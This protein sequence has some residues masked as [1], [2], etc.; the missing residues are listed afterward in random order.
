M[1][2]KSEV[3]QLSK[4]AAKRELARLSEEIARANIAYHQED[5]PE[6][7][8]ADFDALVLRARAIEERFP[9]LKPSG[10]ALDKVGA[11]PSGRFAKVA[12]AQPMLSLDNAF[13]SEEVRDFVDR[14]R[15]FLSLGEEEP[16]TLL[17]EPKI[18]GLA[19]SLRYE[20]GMLVHG[21]TRGDGDVGED[22][23]ANLRTLDSIPDR[24][25]NVPPVIE[26]R[27][28]VYM[29]KADFVALNER[30]AAA[31][32]KLFANP[33]NGAAGSLRQL[34]VSVT[35][36]RPLRFYA[37]GWG[38]VSSLTCE[39]QSE[40]MDWLAGLGFET[41]ERA[42]GDTDAAL[43]FYR[44]LEEQ[45]GDLAFDIDG[46][47][48][49]I[50]RLDWQARLGKVGRAPRWAVAHKFPAEKAITRLADIDHQVGRTGKL[51]PVARLDP[52]TVGGVVVTNATLHN[53]DEIARLD[54]RVGDRV[55]LQ[56]AGDVIPQ[57]LRHVPEKGHDK[58]PVYEPPSQCPVCTSAAVR[59]AGEVARRCTGGLVCE[60]QSVE[61]LKHFV[62]RRAIDIDGL[63]EQSIRQFH[64]LGWLQSPADIYRL[65]QRK[66]DIETLEG[67]AELSVQNLLAA[68]DARRSPALSRFL[69]A[70]G[71]RHIG[72]ITARDVARSYESWGRVQALLTRLAE[73]ASTAEPLDDEVEAKFAKR[74]GD[75]LAAEVAIAGIGPEV[76]RA[77]ADFWA[78]DHNREAVRD[79]LSEV[80]PADEVFTTVSSDVAGRTIVFTG[81]LE[82]VSRDEAKAQAERLGA[83]V[84]GSV[85]VKTDLLV[86]G[87][88]AGSKLKK[89]GELGI[90]VIDEARWLEIVAGAG[91]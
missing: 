51:T 11:P 31:G 44:E 90:E 29:R 63:G 76:A 4:T 47:V 19:V 13:S 26:V 34:D 73:C 38:E 6:I 27:G 40:V 57:I 37:Y 77:L 71:I 7:S 36:S 70:L 81:K 39:R 89:A 67:W 74:L 83:K 35:A 9:T 55:E 64:T 68:I 78:E 58:R 46:V 20:K 22:I 87:P 15:R 25:E 10:S 41:T 28:E 84:S 5:A 32:E 8:D 69:F 53:E 50:D 24:L 59:E 91:P 65:H 43:A 2:A 61:R 80:A 82:S 45:R 79:L 85:S 1:A 23:T 72:E 21:A 33:R 17:A 14:V 49:K 16:V 3:K 88:G 18:D 48:Y 66:E 42:L 30:Q 62:S 12:H 86:T 56:R 60:A 52:V 54:V 75:T